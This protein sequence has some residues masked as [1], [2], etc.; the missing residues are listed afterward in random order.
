MNINHHPQHNAF[1][2]TTFSGKFQITQNGNSLSKEDLGIFTSFLER[3]Y[4]T[5]DYKAEGKIENEGSFFYTGSPNDDHQSEERSLLFG[6]KG[7]HGQEIDG[8]TTQ[9]TEIDN[10]NYWNA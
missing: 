3:E 9:I 1:N 7:Y 2:T 8:K 10:T 5:F 4:S 6:D